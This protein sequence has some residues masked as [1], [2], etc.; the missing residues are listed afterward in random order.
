MLASLLMI[1]V[2]WPFVPQIGSAAAVSGPDGVPVPPLPLAAGES[3][4][5]PQPGN[6]ASSP[7]PALTPANAG[8]LRRAGDCGRSARASLDKPSTSLVIKPSSPIAL[9]V[10]TRPATIAGADSS[11]SSCTTTHK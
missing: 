3:V 2:A 7:A 8:K 6:P 1:A 5:L 10:G 11:R 4:E 9:L